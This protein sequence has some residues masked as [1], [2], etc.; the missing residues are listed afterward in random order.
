MSSGGSRFTWFTPLST[1]FG[2]QCPKKH[3]AFQEISANKARWGWQTRKSIATGTSHPIV[4]LCFTHSMGTTYQEKSRLR[5][6]TGQLR[7]MFEK[8]RRMCHRCARRNLNARTSWP[9]CCTTFKIGMQHWLLRRP[10]TWCGCRWMS[11]FLLLY[12][13]LWLS[14]EGYGADWTPSFALICQW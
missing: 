7:Y 13:P 6:C 9:N 14:P 2:R 10:C 12:I 5:Q 3:R 1:T 4:S 8:V 11:W